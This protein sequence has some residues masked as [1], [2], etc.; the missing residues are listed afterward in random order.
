MRYLARFVVVGVAVLVGHG[1]VRAENAAG[2]LDVA[3]VDA[4]VRRRAAAG[5]FSGAVLVA[6]GGRVLLEKAY[7]EADR[8]RRIA[9]AVDTRF[10]YGSMGKMFTAVAVMQLVQAGRVGL[11]DAVGKHLPDYP[12]REVAGQ[13]TVHHLLTHTG[14]TVDFFGPGYDRSGLKEVKDYIA[15]GGRNGVEFGPGSRFAYSNYG[16]ILLGRIVE[17]ASGEN[18]Y[19]YVRKNV[20][21]RAGMAATG[22]EPEESGVERLAVGY[23]TVRVED[24]RARSNADRL[25]Y[26]GTPAGGGYSTVGDLLRFAE[27]LR[28]TRLLDARHTELLLGG[29]V[30]SRKGKY[31]YGF[32]EQVSDGVRRVGHGGA[33]PGMNGVLTMYPESGFVVAVLANIDPPAAGE[34]ERWIRERLPRE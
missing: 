2:E 25:P 31:A 19:D 4:E 32:E 3:A 1:A 6:K 13:V 22:S 5:E 7:G 29:K 17:A 15:A 28:G 14:G 27:A 33:F 11:D 16:Y 8:E 18:Y 24:G 9:N 21:E 12:N 20:F 10:R 26:R 34:V 30:E 23:T